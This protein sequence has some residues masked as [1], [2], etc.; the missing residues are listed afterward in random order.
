[1]A[2]SAERPAG[3][4]ILV[5]GG[6]RSGKSRYALAR[7][8]GLPGPHLYIATATAGDAEMAA[9]IRH[10]Q[11]ER[12]SGWRTVEEP[13]AVVNHLAGAPVVLLDCLTLW[14]ANLLAEEAAGGAS[15]DAWLE[16]AFT[17]LTQALAQA[18]GTV[19]AVTNEVGLGIVPANAL[20]RRFRDAAGRLA[21]LVAAV[22]DEVVLV[23]A[24]V[25]LQVK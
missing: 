16:A 1:M 8:E 24:G 2:H 4:K 14:L 12:G 10:H 7:A 11:A 5:T 19:I 23:V 22:C 13:L 18:P 17:G 21:Q 9:R 15:G 20:A 6:A 25:P 3:R